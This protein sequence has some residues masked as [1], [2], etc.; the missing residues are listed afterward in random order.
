RE[1]AA[2]LRRS[3]TLRGGEQISE[4]VMAPHVIG[5]EGS[6]EVDE[7]TSRTVDQTLDVDQVLT[8]YG[9]LLLRHAE[10]RAHV[11]SRTRSV[12]EVG[13]C[14]EVA[15]LRGSGSIPT[16]PVEPAVQLLLGDAV[17]RSGRRHADGRLL[18][19]LPRVS[20]VGLDEERIV[21]GALEE[22][23][24]RITCVRNALALCR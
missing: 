2:A 17:C 16:A 8:L 14:G 1:A 10:P 13:K 3:L 20:A 18:G 21:P 24:E 19:R 6:C 7:A 4:R 15:P 9:G 5:E 23:V 12:A 22:V 11:G